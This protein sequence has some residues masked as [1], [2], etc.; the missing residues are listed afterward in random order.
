MDYAKTVADVQA[1]I[2]ADATAYATREVLARR[3][4]ITT[5]DTLPIVLPEGEW[6]AYRHQRTQWAALALAELR[7]NLAAALGVTPD[8]LDTATRSPAP[9]PAVPADDWR[10][11][12]A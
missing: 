7:R 4:D 2:L 5:A 3:H 9:A 12:D 1:R 6:A 10:P 11:T 8:D